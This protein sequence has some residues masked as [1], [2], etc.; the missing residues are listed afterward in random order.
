MAHRAVEIDALT[1]PQDDG[2]VEFRMHYDGTVKGTLVEASFAP[3][4]SAHMLKC[5]PFKCFKTS[6]EVIRLAVMM[7]VRFPLSLR[8]VEDLLHERGID[9]SHEAMRYW[10]HRFGPIFAA[11]IRACCVHLVSS[12]AA[13]K[14][15]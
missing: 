3:P 13:L 11:E 15:L 12:P 9:V 2:R 8:N 14:K 5:D 6:R 7:Y 10:W 1:P 4:Y